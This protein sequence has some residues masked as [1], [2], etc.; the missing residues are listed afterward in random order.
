LMPGASEDDDA[1]ELLMPGAFGRESIDERQ[2]GKQG[3]EAGRAGVL[4]SACSSALPKELWAGLEELSAGQAG[5][6]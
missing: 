2:G 6:S 4:V 1:T 5:M 3:N